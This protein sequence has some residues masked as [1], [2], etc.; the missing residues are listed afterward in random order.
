MLRYSL[1]IN[2]GDTQMTTIYTAT[3]THHSISRARVVD[4]GTDLATA[5]QLAAKEFGD[6][7]RD[8][9]I[10]VY[11]QRPNCAPEVYATRKVSASKW[12]DQ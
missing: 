12:E 6:E 3:I 4:C 7:F 1:I 9:T 2:K 5:K 10:K 11:G 8:H